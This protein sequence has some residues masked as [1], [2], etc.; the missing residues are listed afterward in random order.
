M[1]GMSDG[2]EEPEWQWLGCPRLECWQVVSLQLH[3]P[4]KGGALKP[5]VQAVNAEGGVKALDDVP[6]VTLTAPL[7]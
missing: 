4:Q 5:A 6:H 1:V 7:L 2:Q 3:A